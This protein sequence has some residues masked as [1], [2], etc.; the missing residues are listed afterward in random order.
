LL[1]VLREKL[2]NF[3]SFGYSSLASNNVAAAFAP[4]E[5]SRRLHPG[6][7]TDS[8]IVAAPQMGDIAEYGQ[9]LF[10]ARYKTRYGKDPSPEAVRWYEG[11]KL[12][13]KGVA[14]ALRPGAAIGTARRQIR[15]WLAS[16]DRPDAAVAG[17][18]DPF[19]STPITMFNAE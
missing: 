10:A 14:A 15:D 13:L 2:G 16:L 8:F 6:Y 18:A 7:Y 17:S 3:T 9:T 12:I 11:A 5:S 19:I 1:R 4:T